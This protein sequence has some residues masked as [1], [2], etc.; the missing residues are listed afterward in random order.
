MPEIIYEFSVEWGAYIREMISLLP[1]HLRFLSE[2]LVPK[3]FSKVKDMKK[4]FNRL[5]NPRFLAPKR[6]GLAEYLEE[7]SKTGEHYVRAYES[8]TCWG[9]GSVGAALALGDLGLMAGVLSG[10]ERDRGGPDRD[11]NVVETKCI[12]LG[13]PYRSID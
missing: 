7:V 12:G 5:L 9:F 8:T 1:W 2:L 3:D 4:L 10:F 13:D 6:Y 11:W